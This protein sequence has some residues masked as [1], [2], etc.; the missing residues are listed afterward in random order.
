MPMLILLGGLAGISLAPTESLATLTLSLQIFAGVL[1][2]GP[3]SLFMAKYGRRSGFLV[4]GGFIIIGGLLGLYALTSISFIWL[5]V[6]HFFLGAGIACLGYMRFATAEAV[7]EKFKA[8]AMSLTLASGLIATLIAS[9]IFSATKDSISTTPLAGAYLAVAVLG[10]LGCLPL[11]GIKIGAKLKTPTPNIATLDKD[12]KTPQTI[13][14][15]AVLSRNP[16]RLAIISAAISAAIMTFMMVPTPLAM[17]GHGHN[18]D[19]AGS[20][21]SWHLIA[22]FAPGFFTGWL[23]QKFGNIK[24]ILVGLFLLLTASGF[25]LLGIELFNFYISLFLLGVGWNFGFTGGSHLLQ[26]SLSVAERGKL[27]GIND[28]FIALSSTFASLIAGVVI[29]NLSWNAVALF[30]VPFV[31][32]GIFIT[33]LNLPKNQRDTSADLN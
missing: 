17:I 26:Q 19:Q 7:E 14:I 29:A 25:A 1:V 33:L 30:V 15:K 5:I 20:V 22:M 13:S 16:V 4:G 27:Q 11:I 10:L 32:I 23:I 6:G 8:S 3:I 21:I 9:E 2:T 28:T 24:I 18:Q 12:Q 31:L